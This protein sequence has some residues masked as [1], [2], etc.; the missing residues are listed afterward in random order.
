MRLLRGKVQR[1]LMHKHGLQEG[2][3]ELWTFCGDGHADSMH[4]QG[5][6]G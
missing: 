2:D 1:D 4:D 3:V 5:G 6:L